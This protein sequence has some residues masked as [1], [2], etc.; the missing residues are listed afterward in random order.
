VQHPA[1]GSAEVGR[2]VAALFLFADDAEGAD[3][4]E[5]GDEMLVEI[6]AKFRVGQSVHTERFGVVSGIVRFFEMAGDVNHQDEFFVFEGF[7]RGVFGI[8]LK[9]HAGAMIA[10]GGFAEAFVAR[11]FAA[12]DSGHGK[13]RGQQTD[14][15]ET[16]KPTHVGPPSEER[17]RRGEYVSIYKTIGL[18]G[19]IGFQG[20]PRA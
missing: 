18:V 20:E 3:A 12:G 10:A 6:F 8:F 14:R 2:D 19:W 17:V 5:G 9:A 1:I 15:H 13:T 7:G 4:L 16:Q 11:L